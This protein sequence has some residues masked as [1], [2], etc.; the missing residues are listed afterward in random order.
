M[1]VDGKGV[2]LVQDVENITLTLKKTK[3]IDPLMITKQKKT[4]LNSVLEK[5]CVLSNWYLENI[6]PSFMKIK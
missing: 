2:G 5:H 3:T 1:N 6:D 4:P